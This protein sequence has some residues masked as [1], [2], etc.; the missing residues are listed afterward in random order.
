MTEPGVDAAREGEAQQP[1]PRNSMD[2]LKSMSKDSTTLYLD[3]TPNTSQTN[4]KIQVYYP[5]EGGNNNHNSSANLDSSSRRQSSLGSVYTGIDKH[6]SNLSQL[7]LPSN[8]D[9]MGGK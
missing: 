7:S 8:R 2:T 3:G 4:S 9:S 6:D 5:V 1:P